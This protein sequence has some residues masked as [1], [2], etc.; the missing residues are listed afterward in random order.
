VLDELAGDRS[1]ERFRLEYEKLYRTLKKS[2][3]ARHSQPRPVWEGAG[4][5]AAR[6]LA[7]RSRRARHDGPA[8]E[9]RP[10]PSPPPPPLRLLRRRRR[11]DNEKRLVRKCR[12]L[13]GEIVS[14][15]AKARPRAGGGRGR[16]APLSQQGAA[17]GRQ[18]SRAARAAGGQ[19]RAFPFRPWQY[20]RGRS[21]PAAAA[22]ARCR[23]RRRRWRPP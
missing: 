3:G 5:G 7:A 17:R 19:S 10:T 16:P 13:N 4:A 18:S 9:A 23:A 1:L 15:A 12:D 2:H 20:A 8:A 22:A 21:A 11:A 6:T 14:N